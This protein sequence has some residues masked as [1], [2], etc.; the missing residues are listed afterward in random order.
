M[1]FSPS[2]MVIITLMVITLI[3]HSDIPKYTCVQVQYDIYKKVKLLLLHVCISN[4]ISLTLNNAIIIIRHS[5]RNFRG[6]GS[7][8]I[9]RHTKSSFKRIQLGIISVRLRIGRSQKE[10]F[11][12]RGAQLPHFVIFASLLSGSGCYCRKIQ[13]V[14]Y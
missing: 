6:Q 13:C 2:I 12:E 9:K 11:R 4:H 8:P 10:S 14:V 5:T 7:S 3:F 1:Q